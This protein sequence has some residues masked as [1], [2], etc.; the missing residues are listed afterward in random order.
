MKNREKFEEFKK[1]LLQENEE[2]YGTEI[3]EKYGEDTVAESNAK[4]MNLSMEE[5]DAMQKIGAEINARLEKAV[6]AGEEPAGTEGQ[7]I[8]ALHKKWLSYTWPKYS[9]QAHAGLVQMYVADERFRMYYD[10]NV[11]GCAAFL[12]AAVEIYVG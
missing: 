9:G 8:A 11:E 5:Y 2:K 3:R 7:E 10:G 6:Q 12:K 1:E 4:M